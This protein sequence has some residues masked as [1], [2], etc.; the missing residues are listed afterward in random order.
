MD[1]QAPSS[2][3]SRPPV[4][5]PRPRRLVHSVPTLLSPAATT[6]AVLLAALYTAHF[7]RDLLVPILFS[8]LIAMLLAGPVRGL[9]ALR[10]PRAFAAALMVL[11][12][13]A[14]T[15]A[16]LSSLATP[17]Q[18][19]MERAPQAALRLEKQLREWRRPLRA[20]SEATERVMSFAQG[21]DS[22]AKRDV[23]VALDT[24]ATGLLRSAPSFL[25][26]VVAS[27][28]L[29]FLL[30]MYGDELLRKSLALLP[31]F[32]AK[33]DFVK[34]TREVQREFSRYLLTIS[35]INLGLGAATA[36]ALYLMSVPDPLLWGGA[37]ALLNFAPYI[38]PTLGAVML[39]L[40]GY[41]DPQGTVHALAPA[42]VFLGL[43]G[44]ESQ[45]VTPMLVGRRMALDPVVIF[46]ALLLFGWLWGI[47]GLLM[48]VPLL[49][50]LKV[51]AQHGWADQRWLRL[52]T[53]KQNGPAT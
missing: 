2:F 35:A 52:L 18:A 42:A 45:V 39:V 36:T 3:P 53:L 12:T 20:A 32:R 21:D 16:L 43:H 48:T 50:C 29:V 27:V 28:F 51:V 4:E 10:V 9:C 47:A 6:A 23:V 31:R 25:T 41:S 33:I 19:W 46:L 49:T 40:V 17:A 37:V 8:I 38:G 11:L 30:L 24:P 44:L 7:A 26:S 15:G 13:L 14:V 34:A 5:R 22:A 1:D